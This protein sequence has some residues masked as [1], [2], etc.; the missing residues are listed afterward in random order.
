LFIP[1]FQNRYLTRMHL[2][3]MSHMYWGTKYCFPCFNCTRPY[4]DVPYSKFSPSPRSASTGQLLHRTLNTFETTMSRSASWSP[5]KVRRPPPT[6]FHYPDTPPLT[7]SDIPDN[8]REQKMPG[9]KWKR[10]SQLNTFETTALTY[11]LPHA[12][13]R[14]RQNIITTLGTYYV[15]PVKLLSQVAK[16][17]AEV[18]TT[19]VI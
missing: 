12:S 3:H 1:I 16:K 11:N 8:W 2:Q 13:V 10:H 15:V 18:T 19:Q 9:I 6:R 5:R 17:F 4:V 14:Q 7:L